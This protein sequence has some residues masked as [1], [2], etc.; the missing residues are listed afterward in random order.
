MK[1]AFCKLLL[2]YASI[3]INACTTMNETSG[4]LFF[5]YILFHFNIICTTM[6][7]GLFRAAKLLMFT[8]TVLRVLMIQQVCCVALF[9]T[10][11]LAQ[12]L[13]LP[14]HY[15]DAATKATSRKFFSNLLQVRK[16]M[17]PIKS[18]QPIKFVFSCT[19]SDRYFVFLF[20]SSF[21]HWWILFTGT[22]NQI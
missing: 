6:A 13:P 1:I 12:C 11:Y 21:I 18:W 5:P 17:L 22:S 10:T 8:W 3:D 15:G 9:L 14:R 20:T 2:S 7:A 4:N 16:I 19:F